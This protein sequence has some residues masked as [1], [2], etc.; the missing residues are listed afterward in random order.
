MHN[1][2]HAEKRAKSHCNCIGLKELRGPMG[3]GMY[4]NECNHFIIVLFV[5][6]MKGLCEARAKPCN[7]LKNQM[8]LLHLGRWTPTMRLRV[9][10]TFGQMDP[11]KTIDLLY[12]LYDH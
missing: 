8:T 6:H 5:F 9:R 12:I 11:P 10:M 4:R 1:P 7:V 2:V 3:K